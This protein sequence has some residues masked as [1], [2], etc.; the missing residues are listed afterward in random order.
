M[1]EKKSKN[2]YNILVSGDSISKGVIFDEEKM[3]YAI[4]RDN[5]VSLVQKKLNGIVNNTSKFGNTVIKGIERL[6]S[7]IVKNKPD[8]VLI[9]YGGNDCDYKW[10]EIAVN[11]DSQYEPN[12]S[13]K[14]FEKTL[15]D[16]IKMLKEKRIIPVLMTLPHLIA[17][18]YFKWLCNNDPH[19]EKNVLKW[20][21]SIT[22]IYWWQERY[23]S[24]IIKIAEKTKTRWID[25][26]GAFLEQPDFRKFICLDGIHPNVE[27]QKLIAE[28]IIDF[29]K[30]G[31][32][33]LLL[34]GA[35]AIPET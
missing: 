29:I 15:S 1:E 10:D 33:D 2:G 25:I 4:S 8:V 21:G 34:K 24:S 12:T 17:Y 35:I 30:S 11:P 9:E 18:N 28:K 20:L 23:N 32:E 26:R 22:R 27:G 19:A 16:G 6:K 5:Y 3:K 13:I 31:Y 14:V 7:E